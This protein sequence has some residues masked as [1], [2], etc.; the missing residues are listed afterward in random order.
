MSLLQLLNGVAAYSIVDQEGLWEEA[1]PIPLSACECPNRLIFQM[2]TGTFHFSEGLFSYT[3]HPQT[4]TEIT[5]KQLQERAC[6]AL[7]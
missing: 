4:C 1:P 2:C 5:T 3:C 6:N 7:V